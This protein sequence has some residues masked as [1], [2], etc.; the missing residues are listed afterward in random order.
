[1]HFVKIKVAVMYPKLVSEVVIKCCLC[2]HVCF[3]V[4]SCHCT[5]R[6]LMGI[7]K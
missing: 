2:V 3:A 7:M 6:V 5:M 1:M 4:V